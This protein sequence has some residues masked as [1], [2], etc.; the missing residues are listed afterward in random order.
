MKTLRIFASLIVLSL[1]AAN[2][3]AQDEPR[4]T[5]EQKV[6]FQERVKQKVEEFQSSLSK[7]VNDKLDHNIRSEEYRNILVLFIGEGETYSY[8]DYESDERITREG[9][10]R[11]ET[12]SKTTG[13]SS[14]Q[15]IKNYIRK[16]YNPETHKTSMPYTKIVI[17]S[18]G[19]VRVDNIERV[20]DHYECIA[21][22]K[23]KFIGYRDGKIAYSD[24]TGKKIKCFISSIDL[25]TG[26]KI[27]EAKLGDIYVT[28]T[29]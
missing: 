2:S 16:L 27:F 19:A 22:F 24:V 23:Q 13:R 6:L 8:Y 5:E 18:V 1:L 7:L 17:E 11:M 21:Y 28:S 3:S 4:L 15:R 10:V 14:R 20:G 29:E 9:G 12:S 26:K 25:P